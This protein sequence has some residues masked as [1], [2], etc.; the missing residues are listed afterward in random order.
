MLGI[1]GQ[2]GFPAQDILPSVV[3]LPVTSTRSMEVSFGF[4]ADCNDYNGNDSGSLRRMTR[5]PQ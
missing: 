2:A 1:D 3:A 5:A 4:Q